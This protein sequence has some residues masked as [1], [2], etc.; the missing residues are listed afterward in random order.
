VAAALII[1]NCGSGAAFIWNDSRDIP[2]Q[3]LTVSN[4]FLDDPVGIAC[5][6]RVWSHQRMAPPGRR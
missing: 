3:R 6:D 1:V 5:T 2:P 4:D